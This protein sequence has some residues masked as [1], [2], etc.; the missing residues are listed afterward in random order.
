MSPY[1]NIFQYILANYMQYPANV[2]LI[3]NSKGVI[4]I[5][6]NKSNH[7]DFAQFIAEDEK[8]DEDI[9]DSSHKYPS[10]DHTFTRHWRGGISQ[11][12][13]YSEY[14]K[15]EDYGKSGMGWVT[16]G[17]DMGDVPANIQVNEIPVD[18]PGI[19]GLDGPVNIGDL[20]WL[21]HPI[22]TNIQPKRTRNQTRKIL[23][24]SRTWKRKRHLKRNWR[25]KRTTIIIPMAGELQMWW[26]G[27]NQQVYRLYITLCREQKNGSLPLLNI[28]EIFQSLI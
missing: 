18:I 8:K 23:A 6:R 26:N 25:L 28:I 4:D 12:A 19:L 16:D 15:Y 7:F 14:C 5:L 13:E 3:S 17:T 24:T 22:E 9:I 20:A 1:P 11:Y 2:N 10:D 21:N 27:L